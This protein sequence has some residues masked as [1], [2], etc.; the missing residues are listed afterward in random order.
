MNVLIKKHYQIFGIL[1][2][3]ETRGTGVIGSEETHV[4]VYDFARVENADAIFFICQQISVENDTG[5]LLC[6]VFSNEVDVF[7]YFVKLARKA[8]YFNRIQTVIKCHPN[9]PVFA[10]Y[11]FYADVEYVEFNA[12]ENPRVSGIPGNQIDKDMATQS[13]IITINYRQDN[14]IVVNWP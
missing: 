4:A 5:F 7:G 14:E 1:P 8:Q 10:C 12:V 2:F 3:I 13:R 9:G 6:K 11:R